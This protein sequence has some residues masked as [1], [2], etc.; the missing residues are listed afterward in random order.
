MLNDKRI[1]AA[2]ALQS[3]AQDLHAAYWQLDNS[4]MRQY[5][6]GQAMHSLE[7]AVM[8]LGYKLVEIPEHRENELAEQICQI[9][10]R[11]DNAEPF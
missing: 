2:L 7:R 10:E 9:L 1:A 8:Q 4:Q 6:D 11:D 3:A 5:L